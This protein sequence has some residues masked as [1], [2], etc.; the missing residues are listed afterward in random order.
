MC[1]FITEPINFIDYDLPI[2]RIQKLELL[3]NP[4]NIRPIAAIICKCQF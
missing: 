4:T 1:N 2:R 3:R